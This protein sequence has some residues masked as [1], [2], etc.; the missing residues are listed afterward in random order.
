[1][2]HTTIASLRLLNQQIATPRLKTAKELVSWMGAMQAQ[3]YNHAKWAI[4]VRLP[5]LTEIQIETAFNKGEIIRTHLMRPTWHFV[6]ANDIYWMLEL[7][8]PQIKSAMKSRNREL[9]LTESVFGKSQE[10][11]VK[12]LEGNKS[13][14]RD[15]LSVQLNKY[16]ISTDG[17]RL[18]HILMEAEI[19]RIICSGQIQGKKQTYALLSE[20]VPKKVILTKEE[21]LAKLAKTYFTSHGPATLPD[22]IWW[23]GLPVTDA[24]KALEMNKPT[25][26]SE[27]IDTETYWFAD[28]VSTPSTIPD[29][30]YLLPAFDEYL[31]SYKNRRA[32]ISIDHHKKAVSNNGIFWP[33]IVVNGQISGLW[34]RTVKK[35][36]VLIE[37]DH[38]RPHD[39]KEVQLIGKAA[40]TFG[41][42][43]ET[44]TEVKINKT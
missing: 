44:K 8:A 25:L 37:L 9:G 19:D 28:T 30:V 10:I 43:T 24:R 31:I 6:S 40:E 12:V 3:D 26:I 33:I 36:T 4:G 16:G 11:L 39:Q 35:D 32:A 13:I 38:F 1:M 27:T 2:T 15:E 41:R 17:Q 20:R 7:T 5:H 14:T 22:F 18:P 29:S 34:K 42:Y 21:A 23:S